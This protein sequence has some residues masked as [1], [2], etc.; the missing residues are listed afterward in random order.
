MI[1]VV[2]PER[3]FWPHDI[4][5]LLWMQGLMNASHFM[6]IPLLA[7]YMSANLHFGAAALASVMSANLLSAQVLPL[8]AGA[9]TDRFGSHR[10]ITLGLLLRGLGF[11]GFSYFEGVS[12]WIVFAVIAGTGVACYE[13]GV[14]GLFG[15]QPKESHSALFASNNQMLN[16]GAVVGPTVGGLAG[17]ADIRVA[18]GVSAILFITLSVVAH[19]SKFGSS[20]SF[21][22]QSMIESLKAAATHAGLWRLIVVSLPWFF[23]FPQLYVA[24]PMYAGQLAGP[25]AASAIYVINGVAGLAFI[26]LAKGWMTKV[27]PAS[28]TT[29]A[30]LGAGASFASLAMLRGIEWFL[31]FI[32]AYSVVETIL[33]P[34]LESMTASLATEGSQGTFFGVMSAVGALSGAAGYY[35]GSWLILN[36]TPVET[37]LALGSVGLLGFVSSVLLLRGPESK[38]LVS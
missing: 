28:L 16:V 38:A 34:T 30:Y 12:A 15:R 35:V 5:R 1:K 33:L 6:T 22:R 36:R 14:Y 37:W 20:V 32:V 26:I 10:V 25:H 29:W 27:N 19:R 8:A 21:R 23:L 4:R 2:Q 11:L 9:I 24:F 13:G 31:L 7:L 3:P 17:L 18:F